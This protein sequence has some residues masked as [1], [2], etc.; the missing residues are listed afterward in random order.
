VGAAAGLFRT[1]QYT[2][3]M[4]ATGV[5]AVA[6]T[7]AVDDPGIH[8]LG[9]ISAGAGVLLVVLTVADRSLRRHADS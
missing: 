1:A 2:G 3:A 5:V 9:W 6:Y 7:A 8:V 4:T